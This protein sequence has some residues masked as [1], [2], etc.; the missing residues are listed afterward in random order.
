[1]GK[2]MKFTATL[3]TL[4]AVFAMASC[5]D[6]EAQKLTHS[7]KRVVRVAPGDSG[8]ER[9]ELQISDQDLAVGGVVPREHLLSRTGRFAGSWEAPGS[10]PGPSARIQL[11]PDSS[12]VAGFVE[13]VPLGE[14]VEVHQRA[15]QTDIEHEPDCDD[16]VGVPVQ[17]MVESADG[18]L[19]ESWLGELRVRFF[20]PQDSTTH[21]REAILRAYVKSAK[22]VGTAELQAI[23]ASSDDS[24][25]VDLDL[26]I[27]ASVDSPGLT[28]LKIAAHV[29][30]EQQ[31]A[32]VASRQELYNF[33]PSR[34]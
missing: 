33:V 26:S 21:R 4:S 14:P 19:R 22:F 27:T 17:V 1:M 20:D 2:K 23:N 5:G 16:F 15:I 31:G 8:C 12:G 29:M 9:T 30:I 10:K 3:F 32:I 34:K 18:A 28:A 13:I 24:E 25:R 6:S 11:S 7:D